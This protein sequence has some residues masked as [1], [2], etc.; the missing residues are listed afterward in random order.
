MGSLLTALA[1][2]LQARSAGGVWLLRIDDL[3]VQRSHAE[4]AETIFQQLEAHGLNWDGPV[5]WQSQH[6]EAYEQAYVDLNQ[7]A[8]V[9]PC[10][11]TRALLAEECRVDIDGPVYVGTCRGKASA[12]RDGAW[13]LQVGAGTIEIEDDWQGVIQRDLAQ[14]VGDFVVR[15]RDGQIGYQLACVVDDEAQK[16]TEVVRGPDLIGSSVRQ[17]YLQRVL[18]VNPPRYRHGPLLLDAKGH[19]LSKQNHAAAIKGIDAPANLQR[20]LR[21]LDHE[22][23]SGLTSVEDTLAWA[24]SH[25][26][27]A[28]IRTQMMPPAET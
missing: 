11:C 22:P 25:W 20:C 14:Q 6:R 17:I 21:I 9:Y 2:W 5:R 8:T 18:R 4:H 10:L 12:L 15:R 26:N 23:P 28:R 16:I 7:R 24:K 27:P 13:R 3:D 1:G 19:K